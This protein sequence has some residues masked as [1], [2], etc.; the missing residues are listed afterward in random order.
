ML[1]PLQNA[2]FQCIFARSASVVTTR[3]SSINTNSKSTIRAFQWA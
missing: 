3:K 1:H 2:D